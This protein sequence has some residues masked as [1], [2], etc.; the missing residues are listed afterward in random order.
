[1]PTPLL[2]TLEIHD[3]WP[4][5]S[6][7]KIPA[8]SAASPARLQLTAIVQVCPAMARSMVKIERQVSK[9]LVATQVAFPAPRLV[10]APT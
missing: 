8:S 4:T 2:P 10:L 1:M 6:K 5:S 7:P 3:T 9:S